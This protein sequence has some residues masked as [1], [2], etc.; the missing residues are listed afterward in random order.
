MNENLIINSKNFFIG[1]VK[2][3]INTH[4]VFSWILFGFSIERLLVNIQIRSAYT[5]WLFI[6]EFTN[7]FV[8]SN[9][10]KIF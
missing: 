9:V 2:I 7:N 1:T 6:N 4:K 10:K 8:C 5:N 3:I